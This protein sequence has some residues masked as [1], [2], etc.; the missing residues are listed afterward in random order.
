MNTSTLETCL[1]L[2]AQN[3]GSNFVNIPFMNDRWFFSSN[4]PL[5]LE[6]F[7]LTAPYKLNGLVFLLSYPIRVGVFSLNDQS[8]FPPQAF[9]GLRDF[10]SCYKP[11]T[12]EC[13]N[14]AHI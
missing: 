10:L 2:L 14:G 13:L 5:R 12:I 9:T 1:A 7:L 8:G 3:V 11:N 4:Y 6:D